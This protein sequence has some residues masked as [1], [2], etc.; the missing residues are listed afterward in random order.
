MVV[1]IDGPAGAGKSTLA[2]RVAARLGFIRDE[3]D[4]PE[5][6]GSP[7]ETKE[8]LRDPSVLCAIRASLDHIEAKERDGAW[9]SWWRRRS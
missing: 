5:Q 6:D 4:D 8:W 3:S 2:K 1:A 7:Q 9:T